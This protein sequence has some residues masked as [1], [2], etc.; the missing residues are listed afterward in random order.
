METKRSYK[1]KVN[2]KNL[3]FLNKSSSGSK[4]FRWFLKVDQ[5]IY[6]TANKSA[7]IHINQTLLSSNRL[8]LSP[9]S[10]THVFKRIETTT[11]HCMSKALRFLQITAEHRD[12]PFLTVYLTIKTS[13]QNISITLLQISLKL[14]EHRS[15][16][17]REKLLWT[18][19]EEQFP[20]PRNT[21]ASKIGNGVISL[22]R[23][24]RCHCNTD[25]NKCSSLS[26]TIGVAVFRN[27]CL[28]VWRHA[29]TWEVLTLKK[30]ICDRTARV[31]EVANDNQW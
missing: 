12:C 9:W 23:Q 20:V 27:L 6:K 29:K 28:S 31:G 8:K 19:L 18:I 10:F 24:L 1:R 13:S 7:S 16:Y 15:G 25:H 11:T 26:N 21:A 5:N 4:S 30:C 14:D 2:L 22:L 3:N 17:W